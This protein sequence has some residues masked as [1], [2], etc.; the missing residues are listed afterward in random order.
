MVGRFKILLTYIK[1]RKV[2]IYENKYRNS[3]KQ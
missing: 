3:I 1:K 2:K